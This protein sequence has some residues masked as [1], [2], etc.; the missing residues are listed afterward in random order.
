MP[1]IRLALAVFLLQGSLPQEGPGGS[2]RGAV[3]NAVTGNR[4]PGATVELSGIQH[5]KILTWNMKTDAL[6]QFLFA[7]LPPGSGYQLIVTGE[8]LQPGAYGQRSWSDPWVP[9]R[10]EPGQDLRDIQVRVNPLTSIRG[11]IFDD[12][13]R[14]I[15]NA[16][17]VALQ[18][19]YTESR[20]ELREARV[21]ISSPTG[22]YSL[23]GLS[24]GVYYVRV[25]PGDRDDVTRSLLTTPAV[26][27]AASNAR[28]PPIRNEPGGY[29]MTYFPGTPDLAFA[30]TIR[31][32]EGG[33][34]RN[35]DVIVSRVLTGR[36]SGTV[37]S[38]GQPVNTGTVI[39]Q[40][41][42]NPVESSWTRT[43]LIRAGR[44]DIRGVLP[45]SYT[46]RARTGALNE[47]LWSREFITVGEGTSQ[48]LDLEVVRPPDITGQVSVEG[49]AERSSPN[50]ALF[51]I[52]LAAADRK[53][54]VDNTLPAGGT[55]VPAFSVT[56]GMDGKFSLRNIPPWDYRV[57]VT[58]DGSSSDRVPIA[59]RSLY[60]K[61]I[62]DSSRSVA[63]DG[64]NMALSDSEVLDVVLA[65]DSGGLNGRVLN[66]NAQNAGGATVVLVPSRRQREDLY[67]VT[68]AST[69]G[70]FQFQG[71]QPG[72]YKLF[73][74]RTVTPGAWYDPEFLEDYENRGTLLQIEPD[75]ADYIEVVSLR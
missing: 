54:P 75:L 56:P 64:L 10:I 3:I 71:I 36:V 20:P 46:L 33:V 30:K 51:S 69:T 48:M 28:T 67:L 21:T 52:R 1:L 74:W 4:V 61:S 23:V 9:L 66:E 35:V 45:G 49:W 26:V 53:W 32:T 25:L 40:R 24:P 5:G 17:V 73:A 31:L 50:L 27:D 65:A 11:R 42:S 59:L 34:A 14:T 13:G 19:S 62:R 70:R 47:Q 41:E 12:R 43:A 55:R 15:S 18:R 37:N 72:P 8:E 68:T 16:R 22:N 58:L 57:L 44:F 39:L 7:D 2:I 63:D 29:P 60:L 6:G 38:D